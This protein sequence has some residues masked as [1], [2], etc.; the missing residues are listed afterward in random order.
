M[1]LKVV[2][3]LVASNHFVSPLVFQSSHPGDVLKLKGV[4]SVSAAG[5]SAVHV[6]GVLLTSHF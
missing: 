3:L 4:S 6:I 5:T 1:G 2:F